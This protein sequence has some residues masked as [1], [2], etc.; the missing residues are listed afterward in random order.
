MKGD[1]VMRIS[2]VFP[3]VAGLL[4]AIVVP[5]T[6]SAAASGALHM[7]RVPFQKTAAPPPAKTVRLKTLFTIYY[8]GAGESGAAGKPPLVS[9]FTALDPLSSITC[10]AQC[11]IIATIM[12]TI[13][14]STNGNNW[15]LCA[16]GDGLFFDQPECVFQTAAG[17]SGP[18][19]GTEIHSL[20]FAA[21]SHTLQSDIYVDS[22]ATLGP[23]SVT[24]TAVTPC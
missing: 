12:A 11:R 24:Y 13:T 17:T 5:P 8:S 10:P 1:I 3:I 22:S 15:A 21:G 19:T 9:G 4:L 23:W 7:S 6:L 20:C 14:S 18:A 2:K 16:S